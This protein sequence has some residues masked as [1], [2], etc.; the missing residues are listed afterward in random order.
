MDPRQQQRIVVGMSGGVDSSVTAALLAERGYDV[1][2]VTLQLQPSPETAP[3]GP[4]CASNGAAQAHAV[5]GQLGIPHRVLDGQQEFTNLVLRPCWQDYHRGRTPNPCALCNARIKFGVLLEFA[6]AMGAERVA[7]G[8]YA[9]LEDRSGRPVLRRARDAG[10]DQSYFLFSLSPRQLAAAV[11]P[12]GEFTKAE[13]RGM[14]RQRGLLT[15]DR[16]ESQDICISDL[17]AGFGEFL[18]R[19]FSGSPRPGE[20]VDSRGQVVGRHEGVHRFTI[21]QRRGV[22][23]AMGSP[24]WIK[25]IDPMA[26]R[27]T[28]TTDERELFSPGLVAAG[29]LW[30]EEPPK[31]GPIACHIQTRYRQTPVA[32]EIS[33]NAGDT[34]VVRFERPVRAVTPGQAVVFYDGDRVMGG[35]WIE[36]ALGQSDAAL[37]TG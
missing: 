15:A 4:C 35:G 34:A 14:A 30:H 6:R 27:V 22:G 10:K 2:G 16:K 3:S 13:V 31:G 5:A 18:L 7:T 12:L 36:G 1:I 28:L 33:L 21:G 19:R 24:A 11:M 26:G 20:V 17:E 9:R 32:A 29:V 8:H 25:A 23:I 37:R